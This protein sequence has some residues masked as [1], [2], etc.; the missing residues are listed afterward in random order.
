MVEKWVHDKSADSAKNSD[1]VIKPISSS[2]SEIEI[3]FY[4]FLS[5]VIIIIKF[6]EKRSPSQRQK[7]YAHLTGEPLKGLIQWVQENVRSKF[8]LSPQVHWF[9]LNSHVLRFRAPTVIDL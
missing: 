8:F 4:F 1:D 7:T 5:I 3:L 9:L 6:S 2:D